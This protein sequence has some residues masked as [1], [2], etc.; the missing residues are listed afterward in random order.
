MFVNGQQVTAFNASTYAAQNSDTAVNANILHMIGIETNGAGA[1]VN[2]FDGSGMRML[3]SHE[4]TQMAGRAGRRGIDTVGHVIH[5]PNL[6]RDLDMTSFKTMMKGQPQRLASKF[7]ISY[8]LLLNLLDIGDNNLIQFASKSMITGDLDKQMGEIYNKMTKLQTELDNLN[9][10]L[11]ILRTP[12]EIINEYIEKSDYNR[13]NWSGWCLPGG[14][15]ITKRIRSSW[16][17]KKK[18]SF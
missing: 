1:Y 2:K 15:F 4:Y 5:L 12:T 11:K 7:K 13:Y 16:D 10:C 17:K 18:F 9:E 14:I 8:N 6:Y 3:M